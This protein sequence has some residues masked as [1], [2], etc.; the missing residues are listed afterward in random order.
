MELDENYMFDEE[1][2]IEQL[3]IDESTA[4]FTKVRLS[5]DRWVKQ[6]DRVLIS[7]GAKGSQPLFLRVLCIR[8][9]I[10]T[11]E[12]LERQRRDMG[13]QGSVIGYIEPREVENMPPPPASSLPIFT[14]KESVQSLLRAAPIKKRPALELR[15]APSRLRVFSLRQVDKEVTDA[16]FQR[17]GGRW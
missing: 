17:S 1:D 8:Q 3:S 14:H 5:R 2:F 6:G 7:S 4:H 12:Y 11:T 10:D 13:S 15:L 16:E 9:S